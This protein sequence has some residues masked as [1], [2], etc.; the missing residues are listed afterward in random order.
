MTYPED[1][2]VTNF[3]ISAPTHALKNAVMEKF[4]V[5]EH[6]LKNMVDWSMFSLGAVSLAV[7]IGGTVLTNIDFG[8]SDRAEAPVTT[9]FTG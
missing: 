9:T 3:S 1:L 2:T 4:A 5:D 8:G 6:G 7:A